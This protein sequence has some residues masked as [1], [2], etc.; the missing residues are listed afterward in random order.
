MMTYLAVLN[1]GS[2]N[3]RV[4]NS[5]MRFIKYAFL[6]LPVGLVLV[7]VIAAQTNAKDEVLKADAAYTEAK[8]KGDV[9]ALDQI[10]AD[11]YIGVN[12]WGGGVRNKQAV[13]ELFRTGYHDDSSI[14]S[15][16]DLRIS[17]D[18]ATTYGLMTIANAWRYTFVR[19]FVKRQG[20][21]QL[22]SMAQ[23]FTIDPNTMKPVDVENFCRYYKTCK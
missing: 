17:G 5:R 1:A 10:L 3:A 4:Y 12:Q 2:V 14:P 20:R 8:I 23:L 21:W 19:T 9:A 18:A 13:L 11:D 6:P 22:L 15:Q 7:L 16:I